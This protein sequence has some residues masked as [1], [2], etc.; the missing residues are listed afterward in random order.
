MIKSM[1]TAEA[2]TFADFWGIFP[3]SYVCAMK[4]EEGQGYGD[5]PSDVLRYCTDEEAWSYMQKFR[6][7]NDMGWNIHFTPNGMQTAN[8]K[9]RKEN[10]SHVNAWFVDIDIEESKTILGPETLVLRENGK[11][12]ILARIFSSQVPLPSLTVETR[13]GYQLCWF[14]LDAR[15]EDFDRIQAALCLAF[16]GDA[17]CSK[18][19]SMLRVPFFKFYK[20]GETGII[21]PDNFFSSLALYNQID[22]ERKLSFPSSIPKEE[23]YVSNVSNYVPRYGVWGRLDEIPVKQAIEK[24]SGNYLVNGEVLTLIKVSDHKFNILSNGKVTPNWIDVERNRVFS[25]NAPRFC[26]IMHFL[27]WY[28]NSKEEIKEHVKT[29]FGL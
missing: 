21:Q 3:G 19:T 11:T 23:V 7:L 10:F 25:N 5:I 26:S 12:D 6:R 29:L 18:K 20:N 4:P 15:E 22:I 17:A 2:L 1:I 27:L 8:E 16:G 28:G 14:A 13:N 24:L 9:N